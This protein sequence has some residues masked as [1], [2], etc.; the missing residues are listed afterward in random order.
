MLEVLVAIFV[1]T[2]GLLGVAGIQSQMQTAQVE[3]YQRAQ[4]IVL[5][6]DMVDRIN[7]N[8]RNAP[9][10]VAADLGLAAQD[11]NALPPADVAGKDRCEWNNALYGAAETKAGVTYGAMNGA[12]GCVSNPVAAMPREVV[13]AVAWQGLRS[14]VAPAATNCGE[15]QYGADDRVRRA[16]VARITIGCL[17]NDPTTGACVVSP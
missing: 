10:Y 14:T 13:V 7:A 11:C 15:N 1:L 16:L 8:R 3:A 4:A 9:S 17:E 5:L 12:R 6:Q 2:V